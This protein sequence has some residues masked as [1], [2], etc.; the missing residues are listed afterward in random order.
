[1][2]QP[3]RILIADDRPRARDGL[4]EIFTTWSEVEIVGEATNGKEVVQLM[5]EC[6]PD[7]VLMD[8]KMPE[9]DGVEATRFIKAGWPNVKVIVLTI[10]ASYW[11]D[12]VEAGA[13]VF[14]IK[15]CTIEQ[16]M[17]AILDR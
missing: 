15:G 13:D 11:R 12:A 7:V 5:E 3:I 2:E 16:L 9:M 17:E 10:H 1:M 4:K 8:A 6:L 14:L